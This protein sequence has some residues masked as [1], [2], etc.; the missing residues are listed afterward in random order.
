MSKANLIIIVCIIMLAGCGIKQEQIY[1]PEDVVE[2]CGFGKER[3]REFTV[4]GVDSVN[5]MPT[6]SS[7]DE[8]FDEMDFYIFES[9]R[10]AKKA[11]KGTDYWFEDIEEEGDDYRKGWLAGVCDAYVEK[12]EYLTGNMIILTETQVVSAW[13]EPI[14]PADESIADSFADDK[15]ETKEV[16]EDAVDRWS[17]SYRDEVIELMRETFR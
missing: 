4:A 11:F 8:H 3:S 12:Y 1:T 5:V 2:I 14:E 13:A 17:Q 7:A 16:D 15:A 6:K 10:D 9:E